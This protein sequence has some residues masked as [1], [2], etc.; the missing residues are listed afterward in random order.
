VLV[1]VSEVVEPVWT[2][3]GSGRWVLVSLGAWVAA[4]ELEELP[5]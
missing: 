5:T 4:E 1:I 3:G 2:A